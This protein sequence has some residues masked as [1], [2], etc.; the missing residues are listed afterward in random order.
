MSSTHLFNWLQQVFPSLY[1]TY[2]PLRLTSAGFSMTIKHTHR[3]DWLQKVVPCLCQAHTSSTDFSRFFHDYI[4]HSHRFDWLQQ[5]F[6]WLY[7]THSPLRLTSAGFSMTIS[8]TPIA[9]NDFSRF[10]H[11]YIKHTH[12]FDWLQQVF[13]WLYQTHSPL[14]MTSGG[15]SMT[16]SNTP[17]ASTDFNRFFHD[18]IKHTHRLDWL[19]QVFPWLYETHPSLRLTSAGFSMNISNTPIAS[20]DF[21]RFFHDY[22]KHTHRFDGLQHVFPWLYQAHQSLRLTS[23][24]FS[25]TM[26]STHLFDGR[27]Q[28]FTWQCQAHTSS[29]DFQKV[30]SWLSNTSIASTDFSRFFHAYI[31]HTHR[32]DGLQHVFPWLYQTHQS[33]RL[34]SAGFSMTISNTPIASTDFSRFFHDYIKHTHRLDW[35]QQVFQWLYQIHSPL[36]LTSAGFSMTISNTPIASTDF[37][38][39]FHDYIK[40]THRLDWLPQVFPW[41]CQTN[42]SSTDVNRFFHD[43]VKHTP[44]QLTSEG[45]PMTIKHIHRLD[46]LQ[47]VFPWLYQT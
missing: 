31:K 42:T 40:H 32:S 25:M 43:Y 10:F 1:L 39:F 24:G 29:T 7:Q 17:I 28:V 38:R 3:L 33:L 35:L 26:S 19:Q 16:I 11:H 45:F 41:L 22:I 15:F 18:Y 44:L 36:R 46:W 8:I 47:Q 9:S 37:T 4:K 6:P 14:R 27:Q 34:T 20:T 21:S 13:P 12:R 2:S 30:F 5:V 23:A